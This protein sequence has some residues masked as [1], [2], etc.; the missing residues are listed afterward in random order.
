MH[1]LESRVDTQTTPPMKSL[2][3]SN[4][5]SRARAL[6]WVAA[7]LTSVSAE[8]RAQLDHAVGVVQPPGADDPTGHLGNGLALHDADPD[9]LRHRLAPPDLPVFRPLPQVAALERLAYDR[10]AHHGHARFDHS[11][12]R[13]QLVCQFLSGQCGL[14]PREI[15][16]SVTRGLVQLPAQLG[17]H[18][19]EG[20]EQARQS[21]GRDRAGVEPALM[22]GRQAPIEPGFEV[23]LGRLDQAPNPGRERLADSGRAKLTANPGVTQPVVHRFSHPRQHAPLHTSR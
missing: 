12:H 21:V 16:Q 2:L 20:G 10:R 22:N 1:V 11:Q 17:V 13:R 5:S 18:L 9:R 19:L 23:I 15:D 6:T 7:V 14:D 8:R 4:V 3:A